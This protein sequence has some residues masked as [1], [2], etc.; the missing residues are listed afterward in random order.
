M[1]SAQVLIVEDESIVAADLEE[2]L[3]TLGYAVPATATSGQEALQQ[4]AVCKPD[5]VL[6]DIVLRGELDGIQTAQQIRRLHDLPII[7]LTSHAD[8]GTLARASSSEPDG[9]LVKPFQELE[10]HA[11]IE[12][13]F[14]R[15]RADAARRQ[16]QLIRLEAKLAE[17][18]ERMEEC[19]QSRA[20]DLESAYEELDIF[21]RL[22]KQELRL[23]LRAVSAF[24]KVIMEQTSG[25][26]PADAARCLQIIRRSARHMDEVI[27][28]YEDLARIGQ[29]HVTG[30]LVDMNM[31][32]REAAAQLAVQE[33]RPW[34]EF[35]IHS[36]PPAWG[37]P[38]LLQEV[39]LQLLSNAIK[40]SGHNPSPRVE[41][42][43]ETTG[44]L[45]NYFVRDNGI[46]LEGVTPGEAFTV[47]RHRP[48]AAEF[49]GAGVGLAIV[50]RILRAH[51]GRVWATGLP[52][53]GATFYFSLPS[54]QQ[55][56][57]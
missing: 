34:P 46:G 37:E 8:P 4:A 5:V 1:S 30:E 51:G 25:P 23:P 19:A 35:I 6:M 15:R 3:K 16:E 36:L 18:R 31:L 57:P 40:F 52:T 55:P 20:L 24:S 42:G 32:L 22:T 17:L 44:T 33:W 39:W 9:Y 29:R 13:A 21:A 47:L 2:R 43:C 28:K 26:I 50:R 56:K 27:R 14:H 38:S 48:A 41:A 11:A 12:M 45:R 54:G 49:E 7:F 10:I 53:D